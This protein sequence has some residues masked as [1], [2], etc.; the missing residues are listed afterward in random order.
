MKLKDSCFL[1]RNLTNLDSTLKSRDISLPTS[2]W[3]SYSC[4]GCFCFSFASRI[5]CDPMN[6]STPGF[7]VLHSLLEFAQTHIHWVS[8]AI[9]LSHPLLSLSP[10]D[11]SLSQHRGLSNNPALCI[12]WPKYWSFNFSISTTN[13]YSGL[14]SFSIDW[15]DLLAFQRTLKESSPAPQFKSI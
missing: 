15:L 1:E 3:S 8:D 12:R 6:C 2:L 4:S 5:L 14:I 7:P 9:Q 10:P 13:E 11:L